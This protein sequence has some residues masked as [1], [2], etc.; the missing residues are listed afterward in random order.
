M[1]I[2]LRLAR[3]YGALLAAIL[4]L[5]STLGFAWHTRGHYD[6]LD[7]AL[8]TTASHHAA[9]AP[10]AP[11][12]LHLAADQPGFDIALR[13]Y[14]A[15]GTLLESSP[16][17]RQLPAVDPQALLAHPA[18]PAYSRWIGLVPALTHTL[19]VPPDSAFGLVSAAHARWRTL[20]MPVVVDAQTVGYVAAFAPLERID[21]ALQRLQAVL[22]SLGV[23]SV[24]VAMLASWALAG[25][26]L[27]P[28]TAMIASAQAIAT[29]RDFSQRLAVRPTNDELEQLAMTFNTMLASLETAY[30]SQQRFVSDASHELRAPLTAIQG[31]LEL[32]RSHHDLAQTDRDEALREAARETQR[33]GRLVA[34]LLAL[35]RADAGV[36]VRQEPVELDA[37]VL[38][39]FRTARQ[40]GP[41]HQLRLDPFEPVRTC[42]DADRLR[43]L[44]LILVD[45]A[46]KYTPA[47][48]VVRIGLAA[49]AQGACI[50]VADSGSGIAA[51]DL[52]HVFE[53]F[54]RADPGR[55]R[56]PG[57]T[58]L[59]L[60]IARWIVE[61][62]SG[63]ITIQSRQEYGTIATVWLPA[64]D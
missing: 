54:Y 58:G 59:G 45:N 64:L 14:S 19:A 29:S 6:D 21:H 25:T 40:L 37:L 30:Q 7:R 2:R 36:S 31:N 35:A 17:A 50:T 63:T 55:S 53:R 43:Q 56:D 11:S 57:G 10:R 9:E 5:G 22:L 42:G 51:A 28:I 26:V 20:I 47:G 49:E 33:L 39:V 4:V 48:G 41:A 62:H 18:G 8:L 15:S 1:S 34:D 52:P 60:A 27:Q 61:Q 3:W 46:L 23:I 38:E 16:Q 32:L 44:V 24:I 13:L 12:T